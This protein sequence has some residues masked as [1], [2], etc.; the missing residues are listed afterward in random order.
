MLVVDDNADMRDYLC[1]LLR[2]W[3]VTTATNGLA[4]LEQARANPPNLI[5]TDVMMPEL[6][7]FA[8]LSELRRDS[9][10]QLI[11]LLM[12]SARAGEE[13][14]VSGLD[15]GADDYIIKPFSARELVARVRSLLKVSRARREAELQKQHLRSLFM[16]TPTPIVMLRG[17]EHIVEL[18]NPLTCAMWGRSEVQILNRPLLDAVPELREQ[19]FSVPLDQVFRTG[20]PHVGKETAARLDG[21]GDTA[22][23]TV[24]FNLAYAPLRGLDSDIEGVLVIAFDVT[25]E[26]TARNEMSQLRTAAEAASRTKDQFLAMLGHELRNP[27]APILTALELMSLRGERTSQK[28]RTVIDR[29]VRHL[30]RLVDD[31]LD[32]SR[33]AT[34]KVELRQRTIELSDIVAAAVEATSP[35]L[36]QRQHQLTVDVPRG[37]VLRGDA[38]RLTQIVVNVLSN[39]AKYTEP[40]GKVR[41]EARGDGQQVEVRVTDSGIGISPEMM[42]HI[43]EMFTQERQALDRSPGGLGLGLTIVK[44]LVELHHGTI[45][46]RSDGIGNGS[47]FIIRL[48]AA[49]VTASDANIEAQHP[50]RRSQIRTGRRILVVDDNIDA[51]QLLADALEVVGH[52]TRVAFDGPGALA[53]AM[54][55]QPDALLLDL[56]LPLMDG[57]ELAGQIV[58]PA[59]RRRPLL[60]AVTGYGQVSDREKSRA[61][62]FDAH[63]VKPVERTWFAQPS[64][65]PP[66][67]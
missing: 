47:E 9:R 64:R 32:V 63:V 26:V 3:D 17:P 21:R 46:A 37:L 57:Y 27:L 15:A 54:Q 56:G 52:E 42:P 24:Y 67:C 66:P 45:Q 10:T 18:A 31:L 48:P 8:L 60:V 43:F 14:R 40:R 62:G 2:E 30:V 12:L 49:T 13:A 28:E 4:A 39:A 50:E 58:A 25:D 53:V 65:T 5:V 33:I 55:F 7:G 34:G 36:E 1:Q 59:G 11:P 29:Q 41:I 20:V 6:D 16:Q 23:A 44:S 61:A 19:P 51:A 35:L 22:S 38:T